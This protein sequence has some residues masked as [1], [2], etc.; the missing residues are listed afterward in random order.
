VAATAIFVTGLRDLGV[1]AIPLLGGLGV[2]GLAVALAIRP[3]LENLISGIILF[4]DKPIRVGDYCSFGTMFGTVEKI[5]VRSTQFRGD[6]DTL[7]SIPNAKLANLEL[8]NWK[9]CEQ[10]LILE[11][12]GLRYETENDQLCSILEK[13]REMLHD[14]P[15]VDRETSRVW[16]FRYG[17]L[18][19]KSKSRLSR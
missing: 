12:I 1:D 10:M 6:D 8:V 7:I 11:V 5:S 17:G 3:T 14:H 16:F 18:R 15:R 13:I 19:W 2:G 4:T 9:K